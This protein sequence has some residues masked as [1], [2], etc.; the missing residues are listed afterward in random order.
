MPSLMDRLAAVAPEV[1]TDV[2]NE[3]TIKIRQRRAGG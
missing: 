2:F 3:F 1:V